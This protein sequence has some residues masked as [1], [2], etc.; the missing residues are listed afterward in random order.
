MSGR[1]GSGSSVGSRRCKGRG[2]R[3]L[4]G[5]GQKRLLVGGLGAWAERQLVVVCGG[6]QEGTAAALG[7]FSVSVS[8]I[9]VF[10]KWLQR[11]AECAKNHGDGRLGLMLQPT[12]TCYSQGGRLEAWA[13]AGVFHHFKKW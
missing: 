10:L 8:G 11:L 1:E 7:G 3:Q 13:Q 5:Q 4:R 9:R 2:Q 12:G 6:G